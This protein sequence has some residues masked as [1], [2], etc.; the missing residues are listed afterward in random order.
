M[1]PQCKFFLNIIGTHPSNMMISHTQNVK[2]S[3]RSLSILSNGFVV[4]PFGVPKLMVK[5]KPSEDSC[6]WRF[7]GAN[8]KNSF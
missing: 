5:L 6:Q 4:V 3:N 8:Y 1:A 2:I 7:I